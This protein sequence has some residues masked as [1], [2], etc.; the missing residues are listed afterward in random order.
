MLESVIDW[1]Y[2]LFSLINGS[3]PGIIDHFMILLSDKYIW[4]PLYL[5]IIYK[6]TERFEHR[7]LWVLIP[8]VLAIAMSDQITS[9]F[10]KPFFERL[11]PCRDPML[12]DSVIIVSRCGGKF[13]FASSHAANTMALASLCWLYF[14]NRFTWV[15]FGWAILVGLSRIYLGVHFPGDVVV[16]GL[17]G[18]I[19]SVICYILMKSIFSI[20]FK[21]Q[22]L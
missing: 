4:I 10:M 21:N 17:V 14:R 18:I 3:G 1:D 19:A 5:W 13:G 7:I 15:L 12:S 8:M 16:G 2:H 9:S 22:S 20:L 11:R 6:L